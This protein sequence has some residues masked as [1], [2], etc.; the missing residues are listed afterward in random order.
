[1]CSGGARAADIS[2]TIAATVTI[3]EDSQL[4]GNVTCTVTGAPCIAFGAPGRTLDL[5]G[6]TITGL[7]DPV[8][9]CAGGSSA[10]EIGIDVNELTGIVI[11]G[12]GVVERSRNHGIRLRNST[13]VMVTGVTTSTNCLSG[14][15]VPGGSGHVLERN[16]SIR[17]GNLMNPCGGI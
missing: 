16:V 11:R 6:Y 9:G 13:G 8:T 5:N 3:L 7:G 4:V 15:F 17:N 12:P 14:I 1:L 10:G 2:G